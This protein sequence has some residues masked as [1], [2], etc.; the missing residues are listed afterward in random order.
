[1]SMN[2]DNKVTHS[3]IGSWSGYIYQGRCAVY[4]VLNRI[5]R[6][7]ESNNNADQISGYLLYL[8]AYDDFSIHDENN[9]AISLHQCKLYKQTQRFEEAQKQLLKTKEYWQ[10]QGISTNEI[11]AYFHS[12]QQPHLIDGVSSFKDFE[13]DI[14]F[15]SDTLDRKI[16]DVISTIFDTT[17]TERHKDRVYYTLIT[18]IENHVKEIHTKYLN[19]S[20]SL[21]EIAIHRDS[22]VQFSKIISI[23]FDDDFATYPREE[24][25]KLIQVKIRDKIK[26]EIE[27]SYKDDEDWDGG[28]PE[29][30]YAIIDY[31]R[32]IPACKFEP[33]IQRLIPLENISQS[34]ETIENICNK[35]IATELINVVSKSAFKLSTHLDWHK[36]NKYLSPIVIGDICLKKT[37][38]Q[39]YKNRA[40]LDCLREY[41]ILVTKEGNEFI[42]DIRDKVSIIGSTDTTYD[43]DKNIFKEKRVGLLSLSKFNTEYYE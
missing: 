13:G 4:V 42:P 30:A 41:D 40:N 43:D 12:N 28:N 10:N 26:T 31:I 7:Y 22:A 39:L 1:M 20:K 24:F 14:S 38:K 32:D 25:F 18:F 21:W 17:E 27:T 33:I 5:L 3:A 29:F 23:L 36:R 9:Q 8:D 11:V 15:D 37:C 16:R 35:Y 2:A 34:E 19:Q 6:E